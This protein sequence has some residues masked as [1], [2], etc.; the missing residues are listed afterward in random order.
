MLVINPWF[1]VHRLDSK[2][3]AA[4]Q[5]GALQH[6]RILDGSR[7]R[8]YPMADMHLAARVCAQARLVLFSGSEVAIEE[9]WWQGMRSKTAIVPNMAYDLYWYIRQYSLSAF[10]MKLTLRASHGTKVPVAKLIIA[11]AYDERSPEEPVLLVSNQS[12]EDDL[13]KLCEH[14]MAAIV[15]RQLNVLQTA[16]HGNSEFECTNAHQGE[17]CFRMTSEVCN[18]A[19]LIQWANEG[20]KTALPI[21]T[22]LADWRSDSLKVSVLAEKVDAVGKWIDRHYGYVLAITLVED[23]H[24]DA[25]QTQDGQNAS[26]TQPKRPD[27]GADTGHSQI[28]FSYP[29]E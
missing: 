7:A 13:E 25:S 12:V 1:R 10:G 23:V 16:P 18:S 9:Y 11:V 27:T 24:A 17:A 14:A 26:A 3:Y 5:K 2:A 8:L 22:P 6:V 19:D 28:I 4:M 29:R 15:N 20:P 21:G